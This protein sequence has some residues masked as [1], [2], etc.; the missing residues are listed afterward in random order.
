M[1]NF[2][3]A[4]ILLFCSVCS[5]LTPSA[6]MRSIAHWVPQ[7]FPREC[8]YVLRT[9]KG[10]LSVGVCFESRVIFDTLPE[11]GFGWHI[12]PSEMI[13]LCECAKT[14][15]VC[16]ACVRYS[17]LMCVCLWF[18]PVDR[19]W[20]FSMFC[21]QLNSPLCVLGSASRLHYKRQLSRSAWKCS[22][23]RKFIFQIVME[24][25]GKNMHVSWCETHFAGLH[26]DYRYGV[27]VSEGDMGDF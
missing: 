19:V 15:I 14:S 9:F 16:I 24:S 12:K 7:G 1:I 6:G 11:R 27:C 25:Y 2:V 20:T 4:L 26:T 3:T 13:A 8:V 18:D 10:S 5:L 17:V 21:S 22:T 23:S